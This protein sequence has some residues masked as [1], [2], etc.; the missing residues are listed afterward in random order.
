MAFDR[1]LG[2]SRGV[3]PK[4]FSPENHRSPPEPQRISPR[5]TA[6]SHVPSPIRVTRS[7]LSRLVDDLTPV[8]SGTSLSS[9]THPSQLPLSTHFVQNLPRRLDL[10]RPLIRAAQP[11]FEGQVSSQVYSLRRE[12]QQLEGANK[13]LRTDLSVALSQI[14]NSDKS[15]AMLS[16]QLAELRSAR[17]ESNFAISRSPRVPQQS[18]AFSTSSFISE[19]PDFAAKLASVRADKRS[20][21]NRLKEEI[22]DLQAQLSTAQEF[23]ARE[24]AD[25]TV[26]HRR[27]MNVEISSLKNE[28]TRLTR[29]LAEKEVSLKE[30]DELREMVKTQSERERVDKE[31]LEKENDRLKKELSR[32]STEEKFLKDSLRIAKDEILKMEMTLSENKKMMISV[33]NDLGALRGGL[34]GRDFFPTSPSTLFEEAI[35]KCEN[36]KFREAADLLVRARS[37][38]CAEPGNFSA[39]FRSDI[40]GQLGVVFQSLGDLQAAKESYLHAVGDDPNAHACYANL[41]LVSFGL[42]QKDQGKHFLEIARRLA[43]DVQAYQNIQN[44]HSY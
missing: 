5:T 22:S 34:K 31:I 14:S 41:A 17:G 42:A 20:V 29:L 44:M 28:V 8:S 40:H 2:G 25:L 9:P 32:M 35:E 6:A 37:L 16:Q 21:E 3:S 43:P 11:R 36:K 13:Q 39:E 4:A 7:N 23:R 30:R 15:A 10:S 18:P 12:I 33:K 26:Q 24:I 27:E 19:S 1:I 38:I